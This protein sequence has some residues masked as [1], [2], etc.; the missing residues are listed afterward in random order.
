MRFA[1]WFRWAGGCAG[2][3]LLIMEKIGFRGAV[4]PTFSMIIN[5]LGWYDDAQG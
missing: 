5:L 4:E 3:S 2:R 1:G